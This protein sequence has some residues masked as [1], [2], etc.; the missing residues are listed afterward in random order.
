MGKMTKSI[1][2]EASPEEV[3]A[4]VIDMKKMNDASKEWYVGKWT[5]EG[6]I[7]LGSTMHYAGTKKRFNKGE[8]WDGAVTEFTKDKSLTMSLKGANEH[9]NDQTNYYIFEPTTKGTKVTF[10]MEYKTPHSILGKFIDSLVAREGTK[11]M[12]SLKKALEA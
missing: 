9:S 5:S 2:I 10:I 12:E 1:E 6:S 3:F 8:E 4:F 11:M 7:S